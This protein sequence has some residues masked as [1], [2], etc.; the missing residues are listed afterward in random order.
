MEPQ[1]P[2][3]EAAPEQQPASPEANEAVSLEQI[4]SK[5]AAQEKVGGKEGANQNSGMPLPAVQDT[6]VATPTAEPPQDD[7]PASTG[8]ADSPLIADDVDVLEREWVDKAKSIVDKSKD[9]PY[10]QNKDVS[11]L[12]ADYMKKRYGK[13]IKLAED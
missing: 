12:K 13:E 4:E 10:Q 2:T 7:A 8:S 1:A 3:P 5:P 9:N 11:A 6:P